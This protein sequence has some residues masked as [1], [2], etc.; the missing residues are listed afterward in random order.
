LRA[1]S[2]HAMHHSS[3]GTSLLL[4]V[5]I[6]TTYT[7]CTNTSRKEAAAAPAPSTPA[8]YYTVVKSY[9]H[10]TSLFTEGLLVYNGQLFESTGS[11][12]DIAETESLVGIIDS[13]TGKMDRKI[14]LDR[15][16]YFGE[17]IV[18]LK[19]KLYQLTYKNQTGFIYDAK[20]F[21]LLGQFKYTNKEGW[22]LTTNGTEL[23]MSDGTSTLTFLNPDDQKPVKTLSVTEQGNARD[24]LNELEYINGF[25]YANVWT[26]DYIVKIDPATGN[27]V[28]KIDLSSLAEHARNKNRGS[29]VLN[30]IAYD[31]TADKIY[32]TGKLWADI[33]L[34]DF[35]H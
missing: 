29:D 30:G 11:P 35:P 6:L 21:K 9:T 15:S 10:D 24:N 32:I 17:G 25:I 16:K 8:I 7:G 4:F 13:T 1:L 2:P 23:I 18:F 3:K 20:S 26:K 22:G 5:L 28:G 19:D 31:A 12:S 34:I 27:V 33:Y 14:T